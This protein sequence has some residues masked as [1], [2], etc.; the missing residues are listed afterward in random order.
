M[1]CAG[2]PDASGWE[3]RKSPGLINE[4]RSVI[5]KPQRAFLFF[6]DSLRVE[7]VKAFGLD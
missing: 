7:V 6:A 3:S 1:Y 2:N 4:A 5:P